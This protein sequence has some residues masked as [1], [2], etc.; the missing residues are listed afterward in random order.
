MKKTYTQ[1]NTDDINDIHNNPIVVEFDIGPVI[2]PEINSIDVN[3][4]KY[5]K[6]CLLSIV[7]G[8]MVICPL[9]D[10]VFSQTEMHCQPYILNITNTSNITN[11]V[12]FVEHHTIS[13]MQNKLLTYGLLSLIDVIICL[14]CAII[15]S[16]L[17]TFDKFKCFYQIRSYKISL[18]FVN[19]IGLTCSVTCC[20]Y[21]SVLYDFFKSCTLIYTFSHNMMFTIC[22]SFIVDILLSVICGLYLMIASYKL[23]FL[24]KSYVL[25]N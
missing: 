22:V 1:I 11:V 20:V 14:Y 8:I 4:C 23:F 6:I 9:T 19:I 17:D 21:F 3:K 13:M 5:I 18:I 7:L 24:A 2:E 15:S 12:N 25:K 10:I 16:K